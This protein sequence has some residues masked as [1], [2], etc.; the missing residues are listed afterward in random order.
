MSTVIRVEKNR[1]YVVMNK[2]SDENIA[3]M[4][5]NMSDE[6]QKAFR[7]FLDTYFVGVGGNNNLGDGMGTA[8]GGR[9]IVIE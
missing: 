8:T 9:R 3:L 7:E 4:A 2:I 1:E 5:E 6:D